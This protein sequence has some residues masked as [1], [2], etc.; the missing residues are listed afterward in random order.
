MWPQNTKTWRAEFDKTGN[1]DSLRFPKF[2]PEILSQSWWSA[3]EVIGRIKVTI[4]EGYL[5][6]P[7]VLPFMPL[8][9]IVTF[10]FQHAP[11]SE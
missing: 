9:N 4:S 10:S 7:G 8:K 2:R 11:L 5:R 3:G 1:R 6:A